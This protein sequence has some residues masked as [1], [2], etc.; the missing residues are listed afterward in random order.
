VSGPGAR[1]AALLD[2]NRPQEAVAAARAGLGADP[3][4]G[5]LWCLLARA[6]LALGEADYA[7]GAA[8]R[9]AAIGHPDEGWPHR[10]R[11]M[12]LRRLGNGPAAIQAGRTAV[13][14]GP[15]IFQNHVALADAMLGFPAYVCPREPGPGQTM[16][17]PGRYVGPWWYTRDTRRTVHAE[18]ATVAETAVALGPDSTDTL[19]TLAWARRLQGRKAEAKAV[20]DRALEIG[21][22]DPHVHQQRAAILASGGRLAGAASGFG[23][24][25]AL[26]PAGRAAADF[27]AVCRRAI[28]RGLLL[29]VFTWLVAGAI[30]ESAIDPHAPG[31][32][33]SD[34]YLFL[35][36]TAAVCAVAALL[37]F[38][39]VLL[40]LSR[41]E[42]AV[43]TRAVR[44]SPELLIRLAGIT[45]F[46][47]LVA[48]SPDATGSGGEPGGTGDPGDADSLV[49]LA[50]FP[51]LA[52]VFFARGLA[53]LL[54][55]ARASLRRRGR[56]RP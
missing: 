4:D 34:G 52:M 51:L 18:I 25:A 26:D 17:R 24:A 8:D 10:I 47:L 16:P 31:A 23:R 45:G 40:R 43:A 36:A 32:P 29:A 22:D 49:G 6:H 21:P 41:A 50:V 7:L 13:R 3:A 5:D 20:A 54:A 37:P 12:A 33:R 14:L 11:A 35:G 1:A 19:L 38:A 46:L 15:D 27:A 30:L 39:W 56:S 9:A 42:R 44:R 53:G 55:Q 48:L 28:N 2:M